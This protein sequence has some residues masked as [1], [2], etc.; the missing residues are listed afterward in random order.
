MAPF[1]EA[2][3]SLWRGA[4][5]IHQGGR[6]FDHLQAIE[7][8]GLAGTSGATLV[9]GRPTV[10]NGANLAY[11]KAAFEE[12]G[13]YAGNLHIASG[14]DEF[15]MRSLLPAIRRT[16]VCSARVATTQAASTLRA[17]FRQRL[18]WAAISGN[19]IHRRFTQP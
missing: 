18:R 9:T 5:R 12:A 14:D 17:F 2:G 4:V 11:R 10:C 8:A 6:F 7:F 1:A 15:L 3:C 16:P 13:A 19:K